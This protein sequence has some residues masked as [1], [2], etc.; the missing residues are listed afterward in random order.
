M[1]NRFVGV[2]RVTFQDGY[3]ETCVVKAHS[4]KGKGYFKKR[5]YEVLKEFIRNLPKEPG[6][7]KFGY[8]GD[9][10]EEFRE[11]LEQCTIQLQGGVNDERNR[12]SK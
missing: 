2:F 10:L 6:S 11:V 9:F 12:F 5:G 3:V 4:M 8:S 1:K 7:V